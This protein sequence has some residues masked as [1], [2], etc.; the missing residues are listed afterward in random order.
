MKI[1]IICPV[2]KVT[3]KQLKIINS[4]IKQLENQNHTVYWPFRDTTKKDDLGYSIY[5]QN[6][7]AIKTADEIHVFWDST[8][9]GSYIDLG[10]SL[11]LNK[12]IKLINVFNSKIDKELIKIIKYISK[13][14]E[15]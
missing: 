3:K 12:P 2:R 1:Y 15:N 7:N 13:N 6:L 9:T 10:A 11:A 14:N 5:E 8:S 4:Y